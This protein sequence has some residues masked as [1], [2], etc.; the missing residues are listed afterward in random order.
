MPTAIT[1]GVRFSQEQDMAD[2]SMSQSDASHPTSGLGDEGDHNVEVVHP[3]GA[4]ILLDE[5][6]E[7]LV[8][9]EAIVDLLGLEMQASRHQLYAAQIAGEFLRAASE[10]VSE[11]RDLIRDVDLASRDQQ[12]PN[13]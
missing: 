6:S 3:H 4:W 7:D 9:A 12:A 10:R 11:A 1:V 2:I 8:R 5:A 13:K